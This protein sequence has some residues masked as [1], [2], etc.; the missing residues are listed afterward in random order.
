MDHRAR[1]LFGGEASTFPLRRWA[2][3]AVA[4]VAL[5]VGVV[6]SASSVFGH[7]GPSEDGSDP[8]RNTPLPCEVVNTPGLTARSANGIEHVA[9]VCG[10]VGTDI[11]FQ[12][13]MA[14]DG[15]HDYAF[16]GTMGAGMRIY[17]I[18]DPTTPTFAG[19]YADPG[20]EN[21]IQVEGHLAVATFD[22][23]VGED[24]SASTCLKERYPDA[25]GQGVDVYDLEYDAATALF[26]VVLLTCV[27]NPPGGAH[28]VT[29]NPRS[30]WMAISNCC[31]DWAM[32][33]IDLRRIENN[34]SRTSGTAPDAKHI[35]RLIDASQRDSSTCPAGATYRCVVIKKPNGTNAT[36]LWQPHD[37]HFSRNGK[38]AYVAA[39]NSTFIIDV[40]R[41]FEGVVK[42]IAIIPNISE[43]G[44][45]ASRHNIDIS[46]QADVTADGK[47]LVISD[48]RGGGLTDQ[49]CNVEAGD[50]LVGGLHF[51][52]LAEINGVAASRGAS[53]SNPK[54]LGVYVNPN[55]NDLGAD[56]L[57]PALDLLPRFTSGCTV[58]VFRIGRNG[59]ASPD[60]AEIEFGG[61]SSLSQRQLTTAWYGAGVWWIDFSGRPDRKAGDTI[62]ESTETTWGNTLGWNVMP[63]AS[64]W[65]AKEYKGYIFASDITRGFD[66]YRFAD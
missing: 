11:E 25:M 54:K 10:F 12:S 50:E 13:R 30:Q 8:L 1:E 48:E 59:T 37:V 55:P 53:P 3:V 6:A 16:V 31:S 38:T 2:P 18:T 46:H 7:G 43:P 52:A 29:L 4:F 35:Y 32:D 27:A 44:G 61:V 24:S 36:G 9:N 19:G 21:D 40:S 65:A 26:N 57:Q 58:H 5:V 56:P 33:V 23:L 47:I 60:A 45:F 42:T 34:S 17:D 66:V 22:G 62:R 41:V 51:W 64:T 63:G 20:W 39:I 28:N 49:N 14:N 15:V